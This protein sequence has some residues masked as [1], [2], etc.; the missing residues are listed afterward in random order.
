MEITTI[1]VTYNTD[2]LR[3]EKILRILR[4][5]TQII[6]ADN[7]DRPKIGDAIKNLAVDNGSCYVAMDGN[8]GI[9]AAQN[10]A[11]DLAWSIRSDAILLLDDD[12]I[13]SVDMIEKLA[14]HAA[15]LGHEAII[16]ASA[17]DGSGNEIGNGLHKR[18]II[19]PCRDMMSSGTLISR[20][21]FENVGEFDSGLFIDCV[22]YDW[23]WRAIALGFPIYVCRNATLSHSLGEGRMLGLRYPTPIRHYYQFRNVLAVIRRPY[24]PWRWKIGQLIKLPIKLVL[25]IA[26]LPGRLQR[27]SYALAGVIDSLMERNGAFAVRKMNK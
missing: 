25:I 24:T 26:I 6:I 9:A 5:Q 1:I 23:G 2:S 14:G 17:I 3:L 18:A 22:D 12:S 13:P 27:F 4:G 11:I 10:R 15:A 16:C 19:V 20:H 21:I 8:K 7:S